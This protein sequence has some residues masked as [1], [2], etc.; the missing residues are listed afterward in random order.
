MTQDLMTQIDQV[1]ELQR[2]NRLKMRNSSVKDRKSLLKKIEQWILAHQSEIEKALYADLRKPVEETQLTEIFISL[3]ELRHTMRHIGQWMKPHKVRKTKALLTTRAKIKYESRGQVLI[4][5]PWNFPFHLTICPLISAL[6]AGNC[7]VL[8]PSEF[9]VNTSELIRK[10]VQELFPPQKVAI[11]TGG[12]EVAQALLSKPFDHI[13]FTGSTRVGKIVMQAAAR[14]LSSVTLELGGK[15]PVVVDRTANLKDAAQK[16]AFNK[17]LNSG[18]TCI[19]P[20]YLLVHQEVRSKFE[21]LLKKEIMKMFGSDT[22]QQQQAAYARIIDHKHHQRLLN[23]LNT[24]TQQK[25]RVIIGGHAD[26][27][28]RFISPTL[29]QLSEPD[30]PLMKEEIFGPILPI[31]TF[32]NISEAV[33]LINQVDKPLGLYIFTKNSKFAKEIISNTDSGGVCINDINLQYLHLNLP[34]GGIG[35]SGIGRTHGFYGFRAFSYERAILRQGKISPLKLIYPP[36][37]EMKRKL[38]KWIVKYFS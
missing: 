9:S 38:I 8:K 19:A 24:T 33:D 30:A 31:L 36:Y 29:I 25:G 5:A 23:A 15:S 6:A 12:P 10:M 1:F 14:H 27:S 35:P 17:F 2:R 21:A 11:F 3:A 13:F 20:D 28:E 34:F 7:V 18:Q 16:I 37:S 4:I 26:A 22:K 32:R